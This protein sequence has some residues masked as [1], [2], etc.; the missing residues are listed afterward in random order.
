MNDTTKAWLAEQLLDPENSEAA[1]IW[2]MRAARKSPDASLKQLQELHQRNVPRIQSDT[3]IDID[4]MGYYGNVWVRKL[5]FPKAGD[6]FPGHK[7]HHDHV[8]MLAS[9]AVEIDVEG[10]VS[11][12]KAPTFIT[13]AADKRHKVTALEN[14]TVQYCVFALRD[15]NGELTDHYN[16]DNSPYGPAQ[17]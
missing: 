7:H 15:E 9:G 1:C 8:T 11:T 6:S 2:L 16:G 4:E 13:I 17:E 12:F 14:N 10:E 3:P 5:F